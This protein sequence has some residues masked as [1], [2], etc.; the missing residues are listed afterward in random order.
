MNKESYREIRLLV[1]Q[2]VIDVIDVRVAISGNRLFEHRHSEE[3]NRRNRE[4]L[5]R[6]M[7]DRKAIVSRLFKTRH[8]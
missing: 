1:M 7:A 8:L 4:I 3:T 2:A 6:K 5:Q